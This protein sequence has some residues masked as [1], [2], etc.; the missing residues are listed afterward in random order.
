MIYPTE[1]PTQPSTTTSSKRPRTDAQAAASRDNGAKS[2]GP[3]TP[4][5]KA[6][7]RYNALKHGGFSSGRT[8]IE[9]DRVHEDEVEISGFLEAVVAELGPRSVLEQAL[10]T[11]VA[12]AL[13]RLDRVNRSEQP[14]L[15]RAADVADASAPICGVSRDQLFSRVVRLGLLCEWANTLEP[16][17]NGGAFRDPVIDPFPALGPSRP[18]FEALTKELWSA[19]GTA[20]VPSATGVAGQ[21][22]SEE[23]WR[24][25]LR[26]VVVRK[27]GPDPSKVRELLF[28]LHAHEQQRLES[29]DA[30]LDDIAASCVIASVDRINGV[31]SRIAREVT[32]G[33]L[34]WRSVR[35]LSE[36]E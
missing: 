18:I 11:N 16:G 32:N 23:E 35:S 22:K 4:E 9:T 28:S 25:A 36:D 1:P 17:E 31:T 20:S 33:L 13:L 14:V 21:P 10:A 6:R 24:Q 7:A 26:A 5:G 34:A 8:A 19:W 2:R 29:L 15:N 3:R 12:Y 30:Q 27:C